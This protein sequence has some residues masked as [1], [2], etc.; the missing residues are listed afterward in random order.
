[1]SKK[2]PTTVSK[3]TYYRG[4]AIV[5]CVREER[6]ETGR[7]RERERAG[8]PSPH[9]FLLPPLSL[10]LCVIREMVIRGMEGQ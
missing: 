6:C 8:I 7:E 1:V 2:R 10:S 9:F 5:R 4:I 3:E